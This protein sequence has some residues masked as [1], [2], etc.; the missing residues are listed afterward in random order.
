MAPELRTSEQPSRL[1]TVGPPA[2]DSSNSIEWLDFRDVTVARRAGGKTAC[3]CFGG[4]WLEQAGFSTGSKAL[5]SVAKGR[6]VLELV[7]VRQAPLFD[8]SPDPVTPQ[9]E[10][11]IQDPTG[12]PAQAAPASVPTNRGTEGQGDDNKP[13][14]RPYIEAAKPFRR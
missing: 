14:A 12:K 4:R 10:L 9:K 7:P 1:E 5:L 13:Q 6:L 2:T 8:A 3:F 11:T